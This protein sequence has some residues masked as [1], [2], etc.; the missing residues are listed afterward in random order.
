M[1]V[2]PLRSEITPRE[3]ASLQGKYGVVIRALAAAVVLIGLGALLYSKGLEYQ[4]AAE[5]RRAAEIESENQMVCKK[6]GLLE[7]PLLYA[8]CSE[9]L[10]EV[11]TR[12]EQRI[13]ADQWQP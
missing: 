9:G 1:S 4:K 13:S 11:R 2:Y 7:S 3:G 6:W 12:H 10:D 5:V 8:A